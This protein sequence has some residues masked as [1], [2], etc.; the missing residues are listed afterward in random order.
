MSL[1][2]LTANEGDDVPALTGEQQTFL[3]EPRYGIVTTLHAGGPPQST[4]AWADIDD[5]GVW[6]NTMAGRVKADDY[7][8]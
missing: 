1:E 8:S 3:A 5:D 7:G 4:V 2:R 6:F